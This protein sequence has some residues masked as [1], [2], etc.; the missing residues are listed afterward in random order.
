MVA[1]GTTTNQ[2]EPTLIRKKRKG[3]ER[4]IR[5]YYEKEGF[6]NGNKEEVRNL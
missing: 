2:N 3:K 4:K 1:R 6:E 5:W